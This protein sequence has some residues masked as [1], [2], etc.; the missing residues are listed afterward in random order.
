MDQQT[1]L[2][3]RLGSFITLFRNGKEVTDLERRVKKDPKN[4]RWL[5][6]L[7]E[8]YRKKSRMQE[9]ADAFHEAAMLYQDMGFGS[10]ADALYR[11]VADL[12]IHGASADEVTHFQFS[13]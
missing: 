12:R 5:Q 9:A 2:R 11:I 8:A 13:A 3:H 10:K 4:P 7:G 6:K 1:E